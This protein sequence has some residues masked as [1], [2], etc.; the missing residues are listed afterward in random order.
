M[1]E[2]TQKE[3]LRIAKLVLVALSM[4]KPRRKNADLV[5][6]LR[7]LIRKIEGKDGTPV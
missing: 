6:E 5:F 4:S 7:D 2:D 1:D 3:L